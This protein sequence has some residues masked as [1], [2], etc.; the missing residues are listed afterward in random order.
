MNIPKLNTTTKKILL[1]GQPDQGKKGTQ[2]SRG[3]ILNNHH[4]K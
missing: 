1:S 3:S 4:A 2:N